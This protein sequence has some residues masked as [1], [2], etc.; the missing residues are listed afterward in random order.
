MD[1]SILVIMAAGIFLIG[2][3]AGYV[4]RGEGKP[5]IYT[6]EAWNIISGGKQVP[7]GDLIEDFD[8]VVKYVPAKDVGSG[9]GY[10][11]QVNEKGEFITGYGGVWGGGSNSVV[12]MNGAWSLKPRTTVNGYG[13]QGSA[14]GCVDENGRVLFFTQNPK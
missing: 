14:G 12:D 5:K 4:I 3:V 7:V 10:A 11:V 2:V 13:G 6:Q 9:G 1:K 8:G